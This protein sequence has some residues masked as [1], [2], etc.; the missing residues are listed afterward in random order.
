MKMKSVLMIV[1]LTS[2]FMLEHAYADGSAWGTVKGV[3]GAAATPKTVVLAPEMSKGQKDGYIRQ[4]TQLLTK[5]QQ[6]QSLINQVNQSMSRRP[7]LRTQL[8]SQLANYNAQLRTVN[9]QLA[10]VNQRLAGGT[11]SRQTVAAT[12]PRV[13]ADN[14]AVVALAAAFGFKSK[15]LVHFPELVKAKSEPE[16]KA[17][18]SKKLASRGYRSSTRNSSAIIDERLLFENGSAELL[19]A[20]RQ[21]V[22]NLA[23][24]YHRFGNEIN[25]IVVRGHTN[26]IGDSNYNLQLSRARSNT[27]KAELMK[28]KVPAS[29]IISQG[30]GENELLPSIRPDSSLNRRVEYGVI[31]R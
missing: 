12:T 2:V 19:P 26:S 9:T 8:L 10:Q 28:L 30:F 4:R 29:A 7:D 18:I 13:N 20:A 22:V 21:R 23:A 27:V 3:G 31:K 24:L 1:S 25:R 17:I 6:Y 11:N 5:R 15:A 14:N 16:K